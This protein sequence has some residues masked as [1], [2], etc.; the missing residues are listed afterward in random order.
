MR[1]ARRLIRLLAVGAALLSAPALAQSSQPSGEIPLQI[2]T[3]GKAVVPAELITASVPINTPGK[4]PAEARAANVDM[5]ARMRAALQAA[6]IPA[7]AVVMIPPQPQYGFVGNEEEGFA[8]ALTGRSI[9]SN[10]AQSLF[11]VRLTDASQVQKMSDA[12]TS[13]GLVIAGVPMPS[14]SDDG[15]PRQVAIQDAIRRARSTADTYASTLGLKVARITRVANGC[16]MDAGLGWQMM[17]GR[18]PT[19]PS[20]RDRYSV[21]ITAI[22]CID[23]ALVPR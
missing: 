3:L 5:I 7:A 17:P 10:R 1:Q 4:T 20:E 19:S 15:A 9:A 11:E 23:F 2:S 16:S 21:T 22:A 6:G 12:L 18:T 14:V 13:V 8:A